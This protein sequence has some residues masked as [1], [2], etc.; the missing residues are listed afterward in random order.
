[1]VGPG[2]E[3]QSGS[4]EHGKPWGWLPSRVTVPNATTLR[5]RNG[6]GGK[7]CVIS[8]LLQ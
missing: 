5:A 6:D 3:G 2:T 8:I 7:F 1:M 4:W